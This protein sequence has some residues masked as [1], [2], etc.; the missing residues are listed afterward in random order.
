VLI[1]LGCPTVYDACSLHPPTGWQARTTVQTLGSGRLDAGPARQTGTACV[2]RIR[3]DPI[4]TELCEMR[5]L[6]EGD[7]EMVRR[8]VAVVVLVVWLA[9]ACAVAQGAGPTFAGGG[10]TGGP[11]PLPAPGFP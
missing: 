6:T 11:I 4:R 3:I 2:A 5:P 9:L 10:P 8:L 7:L 1:W